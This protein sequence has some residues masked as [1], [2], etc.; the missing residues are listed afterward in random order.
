MQDLFEC[1]LFADDTTLYKSGNNMNSLINKFK[2]DISSL[3]VWCEMNRLD[4]NW[5]K[6]FIMFVTN[7][8]IKPPTEIEMNG[9]TVAV[10]SKFKL[11][12]VTLDNKLTFDL[13]TSELR[14]KILIKMYSIKKLFQLCYSVKM[15]FF[16][17]F[18]L[19]YF[20]YCSTLS[21]YFAKT[22]LQRMCNCFNMCLL[23]LFKIK[24]EANNNDE[25]SLHNNKLEA[26]G[27]FT[28]EHRLV[29]KLATFAH[30]IINNNNSPVV[31]KSLLQPKRPKVEEAQLEPKSSP[32]QL[33]TKCQNTLT[34]E[35]AIINSRH[36]NAL[37]MPRTSAAVGDATFAFFFAKFVNNLCV[38][39]IFLRFSFFKTVIFNNINLLF[40]KFL[41]LFPKFDLR[42]KNF[43][44]LNK[45]KKPS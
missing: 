45:K 22:A 7:K 18:M 30:K 5:S 15:Q 43:D 21:I 14:K 28:F 8:R 2:S 33:R 11:L 37:A 26:H 41:F 12:G 10:V 44:Y 31:L 34:H 27:L 13:F 16:K 20:D 39:D 6:T 1:I 25:L 24:N 42:N 32:K 17:S 3:R 9:S 36:K 29:A 38:D 35:L 23:K 40:T 4:I 19:P